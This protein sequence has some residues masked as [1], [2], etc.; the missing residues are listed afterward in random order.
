MGAAAAIGL[1]ILGVTIGAP[2]LMSPHGQVSEESAVA[3]GTP[4]DEA[5]PRDS[6][7]TPQVS[8]T[9]FIV[10]PSPS[11][12]TPTPSQGGSSEV[13][14]G[15]LEEDRNATSAV[16]LA[17]GRVFVFGGNDGDWATAEIYDPATGTSTST[18]RSLRR[19]AQ[20]VTLLGDGRVLIAGGNELDDG[21]PGPDLSVDFYDPATG[22]YTK[23]GRLL[24]GG[25]SDAV[26]LPD[27][28]VLLNG[29]YS[30]EVFDPETSTHASIPNE[31]G[32]AAIGL[33]GDRVL[34]IRYS[35]DYVEG[36]L[37]PASYRVLDPATGSVSATG[38]IPA[39]RSVESLTLVGL[40][41]GRVLIAYEGSSTILYDPK[42]N[43]VT[44]TYAIGMTTSRS[45]PAAVLLQDGRVLFAG[46]FD[47]VRH[48]GSRDRLRSAEVYDPRTGTF[49][50]AGDMRVPR[51]GH[52][53]VLLENGKVLVGGGAGT[54]SLE[55][56]DP[57]TNEFTF[58]SDPGS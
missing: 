56:F 54:T 41:D 36:N 17:D 57:T 1:L 42:S 4:T 7:N 11:L 38:T 50:A 44:V 5:S 19:A 14:P 8:P 48:V 31:W 18:A 20:C 52:F 6:T 12:L 21:I 26:P 16:L 33:P 32:S 2:L 40:A 55:L 28:R 58:L 9:E 13:V 23:V 27:G 53:A 25:C 22:Q 37:Q 15:R 46:G 3:Q 47:L 10:T 34:M 30:A 29:G 35:H 43:T 45:D 39:F 49:T 24:D 51:A